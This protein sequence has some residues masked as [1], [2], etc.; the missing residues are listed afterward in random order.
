MKIIKILNSIISKNKMLFFNTNKD[1]LAS[2][3]IGFSI[4]F[5]FIIPLFIFPL[6]NLNSSTLDWQYFEQRYGAITLTILNYSQIPGNNPWSGG[7]TPIINSFYGIFGLS[8]LIFGAKIGIRFAILVYFLIGYYGAYKLSTFLNIDNKLAQFISLY[9]LLSNSLAWHLYAGHINFVNIVLLPY[10]IYLSINIKNNIF[11]YGLL[12]GISFIDG[13]LYTGQYI[14]ILTTILNLYLILRSNNKFEKITYYFI[15]YL[16]FLTISIYQIITLYPYFVEFP[17]LAK[18]LQTNQSVIDA[19]KLISIPSLS[20]KDYI[21][22]SKFCSNTHENVSYMGLTLIFFLLLS[23]KKNKSFLVII[24][25]LLSLV[26]YIN[27]NSHFSIYYYLNH[28]PGFSSHLCITRLR[29]IFPLLISFYMVYLFKK[30]FFDNLNFYKINFN[31]NRILIFIIIDI[32]I[33][34]SVPIYKTLNSRYENLLSIEN[35]YFYN[36]KNPE[37]FNWLD[38]T[39]N[40]IGVLSITDSNIPINN[41]SRFNSESS[42]ISEFTQNN[43]KIDPVYWSPNKIIFFVSNPECIDTNIPYSSGWK[44]NGDIIPDNLKIINMNKILCVKPDMNGVAEISWTRPYHSLALILFLFFL[45]LFILTFLIYKIR[46]KIL[47]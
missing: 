25:I 15:S 21:I 17:R 26:P 45:T 33:F 39:E 19:L 11:L 47:S 37:K 42:Y 41:I 35:K 9:F 34:S 3:K 4:V 12:L 46:L 1:Y 31:K 20:F 32:L 29:L 24:P 27:P 44:L 2:Q 7:G 10:L 40:N 16:L 38:L 36:I 18:D 13:P 43:K 23:F 30:G 14:I 8:S 28:I 6:I 5:L 22:N